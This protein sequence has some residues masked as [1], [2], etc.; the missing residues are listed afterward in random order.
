MAA[1][2]AEFRALLA[3]NRHKIPKRGLPRPAPPTAQARMYN[4]ALRKI[5]A[6]AWAH[7]ERILMPLVDSLKATTNDADEDET[8]ITTKVIEGVAFKG[9]KG[10]PLGAR[11]Q[12]WEW[13]EGRGFKVFTEKYDPA[14]GEWY[15]TYGGTGKIFQGP[16]AKEKALAEFERM[17][18]GEAERAKA[19][20]ASGKTEVPEAVP[21]SVGD[22]IDKIEK[23]FW[24][25]WTR[26]KM[27]ALVKPTAGDVE[28]FQATQANKALRPIVGI[29]VV[30]SEPWLDPVVEKF[31]ARNVA[32][33]KTIPQRFFDEVETIVTQEAS[34]GQR[35]E[36]MSERLQERFGVSESR[37]NL[38]ARDQ[39]SKFNGELQ[40]QR[41]AAIGITEEI[42]HTAGDNRVRDEHEQRE[43]QVYKISNPPEGGPGQPV[44]CRCYG[45]PVLESALTD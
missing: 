25:T 29:D 1:S 7:V 34:Q 9:R 31:V 3:L 33:I 38:I 26:E 24:K 45:E 15:G 6:S 37:A 17:S 13:P 30:G 20:K 28:K 10:Q 4:R 18:S 23:E 41:S 12:M 27:T 8:K 44:G 21:S 19:A 11:A 36:G 43:G 35:W 14:T 39:V 22:A 5:T 16:D 40:R 2:K 32:L 42:W